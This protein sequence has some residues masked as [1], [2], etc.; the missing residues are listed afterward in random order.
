LQLTLLLLLLLLLYIHG[1]L[2][3]LGG[4]FSF[5]ILYIVSRTPWFG[6][7]PFAKPLPATG[8]HKN[9]VNTKKAFMP[10]MVFEPITPAFELAK[11]VFNLV[12]A[13]AVMGME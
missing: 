2:L 4:F 7:Q 8:Q 9:R 11:A 13:A 3:G 6:D 12:S 5:L 10:P 1:P